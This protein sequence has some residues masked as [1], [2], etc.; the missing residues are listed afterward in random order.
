MGPIMKRRILWA[1]A[2]LVVIIGV[3]AAVR[4]VDDSS[5]D[6]S[7]TTNAKRADE[8]AA[9]APQRDPS[10]VPYSAPSTASVNAG[11]VAPHKTA[12]P[13]VIAPNAPAKSMLAGLL[14]KARG[15]PPDAEAAMTAYELLTRCRRIAEHPPKDPDPSAPDCSGLSEADWKNSAQLLKMAAEMGNERAQLTYAQRLIGGLGRD[16]FEIATDRDERSAETE[17]ARQ[18]LS[19]LAERGNVDGMWILSESLRLGEI[20]PPDLTM[21]YAYKYAVARAGGYPYTI[22]N[23]LSQLERQLSPADQ[24]RARAFGDQLILRCCTKH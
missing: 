16:P 5:I 18:Y 14:A 23:E 19:G 24:Q 20:S 9:K 15:Q 8:G 2:A 6:A 3:L 7:A 21:A 12:P 22:D 11:P 10:A 4:W 17:R 1:A 13:P